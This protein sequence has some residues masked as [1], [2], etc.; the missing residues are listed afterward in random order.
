MLFVVVITGPTAGGIGAQTA[1]FLAHGKPVEILLLGRT[2]SKATSIMEEINS[3]SPT[4][5]VKFVQ[6][7]LTRFDSI[8]SAAAI[9]KNSVNQINVLI[10][11]AGIMGVKNYTLTPEGLESQFGANHIGHF[12]ITNLLMPKIF[13]G[14]KGAR[15]VNLTSNSHQMEEMRFDDYNFDNG[16][17][18][19]PWLAYGQSKTA[20]NLFTV[21]L[22]E[23]L[24]SKGIMSYSVHPG[25]IKTNIAND[26]DPSEWSKV[27]EIFAARDMNTC[28]NYLDFWLTI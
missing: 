8:R 14:G 7:D 10:N 12:L 28:L 9:V 11:N 3:I 19:N 26:V 15:I 27:G 18:Y 22:A 4:T 2:E 17:T 21:S 16:N 13:A 23:K 6:A 25:G 5:L 1:I 20:N 24:P